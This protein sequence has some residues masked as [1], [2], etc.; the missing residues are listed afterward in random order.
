MEF[1]YICE[2][3]PWMDPPAWVGTV[4]PLLP[5]EPADYEVTARGNCFH[6]IIGEHSSGKYL[7]I[8]NWGIGMD[9]AADGNRQQRGSI[10]HAAYA[11]VKVQ[12][13]EKTLSFIQ[14]KNER[15]DNLTF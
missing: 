15:V 2:G 3:Y 4:C 12:M 1:Q 10:W 5:F 13:G 7:C 11:I 14:R 8:P 6:V 9:L